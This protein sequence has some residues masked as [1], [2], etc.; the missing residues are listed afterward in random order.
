M[1]DQEQKIRFLQFRLTNWFKENG[2]NF[3]WRRKSATNYEKIISEVLLQRTKAETVA[4]FY[5]TFIR[6]Y[7]SWKKLALASELELQDTLR[8]LGLYKQRGSRIYKL[9]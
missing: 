7:P 3:P 2:R 5:P 4:K 1:M 9:T 6:K 8:P